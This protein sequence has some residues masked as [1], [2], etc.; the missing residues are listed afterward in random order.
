MPDY[1]QVE[2]EIFAKEEEADFEPVE[3]KPKR[4]LSEKQID[5]LAR[6]RAKVAENRERKRKILLKKK[7]TTNLLNK[8]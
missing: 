8:Q 4:V 2:T 3:E 6:G 1:E 7:K 5:A